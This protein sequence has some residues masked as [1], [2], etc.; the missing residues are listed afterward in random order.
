MATFRNEKKLFAV[1]RD[2]QEDNPRNNLSR[3]TNARR[4]TE[5]YI[6]QVS[7]E[8]EDKVTRKMF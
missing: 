8:M 1:I 6:T 2:N 5:E 4:L 3:D 7:E